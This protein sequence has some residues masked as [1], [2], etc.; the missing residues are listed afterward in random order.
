MTDSTPT[1]EPNQTVPAVPIT[2]TAVVDVA[3]VDITAA[4]PTPAES[5]QAVSIG[6]AL[7]NRRVALGLGRAACALHMGLT[8]AKLWRIEDGRPHHGELEIV[9]NALTALETDGLPDNLRKPV[10]ATS[11]A[12]KA[13]KAGA[14]ANAAD[15]AAL[16]ARVAELAAQVEEL[17]GRMGALVFTLTQ[18]AE[19]KNH[20]ALADL[21]V[22]AVSATDAYTA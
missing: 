12:P 10:K 3:T 16:E 21:I 20:K 17:Q 15:V 14:K 8:A 9:Q 18:A 2:T 11:A 13:A 5:A 1:P 4:P 22:D 7:L 6:K 19:T